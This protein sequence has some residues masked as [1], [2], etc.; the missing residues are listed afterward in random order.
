MVKI[1]NINNNTTINGSQDKQTKS[2]YPWKDQMVVAE[3]EGWVAVEEGL[4]VLAE[5][6]RE[7]VEMRIPDKLKTSGTN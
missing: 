4:A 5:V 6:K 7:E 3:E 1:N 2:V